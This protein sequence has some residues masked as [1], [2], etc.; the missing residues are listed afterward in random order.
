MSLGT[1]NNIFLLLSNF[2]GFYLPPKLENIQIR[3][4][5]S[6]IHK[7]IKRPKSYKCVFLQLHSMVPIWYRQFVMSIKRGS[8][9]T[10]RM[11]EVKN[12]R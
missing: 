10:N 5:I 4:F 8:G 9:Q 7:K 2:W 12:E 6:Q 3:K 11:Y 1:L